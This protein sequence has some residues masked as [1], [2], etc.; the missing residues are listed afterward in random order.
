MNLDTEVKRTLRYL[1]DYITLQRSNNCTFCS[2]AKRIAYLLMKLL[3]EPERNGTRRN[4]KV[5]GRG[6]QQQVINEIK[7]VLRKIGKE[8][9]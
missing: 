4:N 7:Y 1:K 8:G 6:H 5:A 2:L 3:L 9:F